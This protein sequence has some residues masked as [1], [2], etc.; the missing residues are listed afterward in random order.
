MNFSSRDPLGSID[1]RAPHK[2]LWSLSHPETWWEHSEIDYK[3]GLNAGETFLKHVA[4]CIDKR[5]QR[6][7]VEAFD[8]AEKGRWLNFY[9]LHSLF[10]DVAI[11]ATCGFYGSGDCPPPEFWTHVNGDV[12]TSF[13]PHTYV[14]LANI[15]VEVCVA[16]TVV[17]L[18]GKPATRAH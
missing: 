9:P 3:N 2:Q 13:I 7:R 15:G 16:D 5:M 4:E 18:S 11:D 6:A 17:W 8:P 1:L 12:V 10:E 14:P